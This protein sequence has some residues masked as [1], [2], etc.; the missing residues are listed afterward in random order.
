MQR[1]RVGVLFTCPGY[2]LTEVLRDYRGCGQVESMPPCHQAFSHT[3]T[4]SSIFSGGVSL[5]VELLRAPI[6]AGSALRGC[7]HHSH[8]PSLHLLCLPPLSACHR[9]SSC[10]PFGGGQHALSWEAVAQR[11]EPGAAAFEQMHNNAQQ[12][13]RAAGGCRIPINDIYAAR[14]CLNGAP[15]RPAPGLI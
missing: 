12:C 13:E 1:W 2:R 10:S 9:C 6:M 15:H 8:T 14:W 11:G 5:S 3:S 7:A 4:P